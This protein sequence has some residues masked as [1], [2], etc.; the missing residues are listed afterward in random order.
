M[1]RAFK[2][3][4]KLKRDDSHANAVSVTNNLVGYNS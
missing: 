1:N 2:N 3:V 4:F